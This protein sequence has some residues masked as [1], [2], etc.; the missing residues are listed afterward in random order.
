[1]FDFGSLLGW[2]LPNFAGVDVVLDGNVTDDLFEYGIGC[3]A[4]LVFTE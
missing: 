2:G 4:A 3:F 1:M